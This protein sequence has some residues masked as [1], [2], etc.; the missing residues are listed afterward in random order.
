MISNPRIGQL[1]QVWY[2]KGLR[3]AMPLHGRIGEV[4]VVSRGHPRNHGIRIDGV[5]YVVPAGNL[6]PLP[7]QAKPE[8]RD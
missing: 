3:D 2:R 7:A 5:L 4:E 1:V 6:R 8:S